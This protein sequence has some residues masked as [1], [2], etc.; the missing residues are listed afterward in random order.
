VCARVSVRVRL[1]SGRRECVEESNWWECL[2]VRVLLAE[3][4]ESRS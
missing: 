2:L 4:C 1:L 3:E